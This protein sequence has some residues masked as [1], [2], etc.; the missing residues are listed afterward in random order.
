MHTGYSPKDLTLKYYQESRAI[1]T[2]LLIGGFIIICAGLLIIWL[3]EKQVFTF[4]AIGLFISTPLLL[5][6]ALLDR[7][8]YSEQIKDISNSS[9]TE[10]DKLAEKQLL[11]ETLE[12]NQKH[13][14][15]C[16]YAILA[17]ILLSTL[18]CFAEAYKMYLASILS[19]IFILSLEY[20]N[21]LVEDFRISEINYRLDRPED[22]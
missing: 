15:I 8:L 3:A 16:S 5:F 10:F 22:T 21:N 14:K 7:K 4:F 17:L 19:L 2:Y 20:I 11:I 9:D 18:T 13:K 12:D 6:K 1:N